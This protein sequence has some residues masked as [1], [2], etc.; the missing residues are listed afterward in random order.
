MYI[1]QIDELFSTILERF[2][3]FLIKKD[4]FKKILQDL[5]FVKYQ[6]DILNFIKIFIETI[7]RHEILD[8]IKKDSYFDIIIN[9]IKRYCAYYI[10]LGIAYYYKGS[11]DLYITN[12]IEISKYQKDALYHI[13]NFY[14][15][16][17]NA[18][19]ILFYN[20]I[21]NILNLLK[22]KTMD[23]IK[24]YLSNNPLKYEST[25]SLLNELGDDYIIKHFLINDNFHNIIF[26]L[27]IKQIYQKEEKN[28]IIILLSQLESSTSIYKYIEVVK[29]KINKIVD[30]NV[31]QQFLNITQLKSGLAEE[32]YEYLEENRNLNDYS[33]KI[34]ETSEIIDYL[35]T[36]EI[37]IPI[38]EE[39]IRFHKD[40]EK[41]EADTSDVKERDATK[42]KYI[43]N[44]INNVKNYYSLVVEK[45]P[46]IKLEISNLFFKP[47]EYR[48]AV[49]FN[50]NEEI[51]IIQKLEVSTLTND[52]D[53]LVDLENIRKYPYIN[54]KENKYLK[55][56]PSKTISAIR[57]INIKN[58]NKKLIE[59]RITNSRIDCNIVGIAWNPSKMSLDCFSDMTDVK[60]I[61]KDD[62]GFKAFIKIMKSTINNKNKKLYYW[63]F[64]NTKDKAESKT[65]ISYSTN[66]EIMIEEL[67]YI[68]IDLIKEKLN[69]YINKNTIIPI[70]S[71][72]KKYNLNL[73][74]EIK[75]EFIERSYFKNNPEHEVII[76]TLDK[77]INKDIIRLPTITHN[78]LSKNIIELNKKEI[79][80][81]IDLSNQNIA[82]CNHYIIWANLNKNKKTEGY[83]QF[84]FD[85]I[86]KY[87]K[88]NSKGEYICRSCNELIQF[89]KLIIS[90][91]Y[92]EETDTFSTTSIITNQ[93]LE[94]IPKYT[95]YTRSI[96]N[97]DKNIDKIAS[98]LELFGLFGSTNII[99]LK[100]KII[101][102][103]IIDL[104]LIH[105]E[106]LSKQPKDR[107]ETFNKQYGI[108]QK[109]TNLFF[110]ELKDEIFLTSSIDTDQYKIIK[111]NNIITYIML[112]IIFELNPGQIINF[113]DDKIY[114]YFYFNKIKET[115]F[116]NLYI[117]TADK[118]KQ[119]LLTFPL[120]IYILYYF[121]GMLI[122]NRIWLYNDNN[123]QPNDKVSY[124]I[125]LQKTIIHTFI[126]LFNTI[127]EANFGL[128]KNFL[129]EILYSRLILKFQKGKIFNDTILLK[130]VEVNSNKF[131]KFD[132][133]TKKITFLTKKIE[134]VNLNIDYIINNK[135]TQLCIPSSKHIPI[136]SYKSFDNNLDLLILCDDGKFHNWTFKNN[137]LICNK[138]N[139][140]YNE[141]IKI[142]NNTTVEENNTYYLDKIKLINI[143]NLAK[144]YCISGELHELD[145]NKCI[146]CNLNINTFKLNNKELKQLENNINS[147]T[148][149]SILE[150]INL[151][152]DN[153]IKLNKIKENN[154]KV[155][156]KLTSDYE[157]LS[158]NKVEN[159]INEFINKLSKIIGNKI[160]LNDK[161]IYLK[162][163]VYII[164]H[165]YLGND[166]K[167][168]IFVL[169][170]DDK[171]KFQEIHPSFNKDIIYY[172]DK[173]NNVFIYYDAITHQYL[174]YSNDNKNIT[175]N[176][177]NPILQIELS[178][179]D[180]LIYLGYEN[181]Y[182]NIYHLN[183]D[184]NNNL[185]K[186]I[187]NTIIY[188]IIRNRINNLKQMIIR[189]QSIIYNIQ[190]N[191]TLL[192]NNKENKIIIDFINKLKNINTN[193][194][195]DNFNIIFA[196][197]N[198]KYTIPDNLHIKLNSNY[199]DIDKINA[200]SNSD[201][202]LLFYLIY[203]LTLLLDLNKQHII[204]IELCN[205]I[206]QIIKYIFNI[207]YIQ[208]SN[209]NIRQFDYLLFNETFIDSSLKV[210][211]HYQE[212]INASE[213]DDPEKQQEILEEQYTN[214][215]EE[216]S[217]DIDDY[218]VELDDTIDNN[219]EA[220]GFAE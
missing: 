172:K 36:N 198:T 72:L 84:V 34:K 179:K 19:I 79:N 220:L 69:N 115:L 66:I 110:F 53:L 24:I 182:F 183:S 151:M 51:K 136:K 2:F 31:I 21:T 81:N 28:E 175:K 91:F 219:M 161:I 40:T 89:Q 25:I 173:S 184:Y 96:R 44:K 168:P 121:S 123:I 38:T 131:L 170:S 174:G 171:I 166:L 152:K 47:M 13:E 57:Y 97:I 70:F 187:N 73:N 153:N 129:Y 27:I 113:K 181:K 41:Y 52:I 74:P 118:Q 127:I 114:N 214:L 186:T 141:L 201:N 122:K 92:S 32:I 20:D 33:K 99:R 88:Q 18:K 125:N 14:N 139:K 199:I 93:N 37:I 208:H 103:D 142:N 185:P 128:N 154:I 6:S 133:T 45:N 207:Y 58:K 178:L 191:N 194:L 22:F 49:L 177:N 42:I 108:Q 200:L 155:I 62:N 76:E 87:V 106:Y 104:L 159:Y 203:N 9:I 77:N 147:K 35:F 210:A 146:K 189:V 190:N 75:K 4:F 102:K 140:S 217:L 5:N 162:D 212:L 65:Y 16:E 126:D 167:S 176:K 90:G 17:N 78:K 134:Y 163:T 64:D 204:E 15:S 215:Q 29:S 160:K 165:D 206:I 98:G 107:I 149:E 156:A 8:I 1:N 197:L 169:S 148:N 63:I 120:F 11:R 213:I 195:F 83:N 138:C 50:E 117:R 86:K 116:I 43:I 144:I 145:N 192:P 158:N 101:V 124:F 26:T 109:L 100:R 68:Y 55:L 61:T 60:K 112:F 23:K 132:D 94:N 39:F 71:L 82:I 48:L 80:N 188:E 143:N 205:L 46:K 218:E 67:Y 209:Y 95:K 56:R 59:T 12:L 137:D 130:Q 211:N 30:F 85:F 105:T 3:D 180:N 202:K 164:N 111:Y 157:T 216:Q 7:P 54:F 135:Y 193:N 150:Q 119:S 196:N 10:Y